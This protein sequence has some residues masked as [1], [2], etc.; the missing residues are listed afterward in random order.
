MRFRRYRKAREEGRRPQLSGPPV[1]DS[2]TGPGASRALCV[3]PDVLFARLCDCFYTNLDHYIHRSAP[4]FSASFISLFRRCLC[5]G[6]RGAGQ[7]FVTTAWNPTGPL[8]CG[9]PSPS[10]LGG[11][12][13]CFRSF[14][15]ISNAAISAHRF[16]VRVCACVCSWSFCACGCL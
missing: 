9:C 13:G 3:L 6:T 2:P 10:S 7:L 12:L 15:V 5:I 1:S 14:S 8:T 16:R 11:S 4:G